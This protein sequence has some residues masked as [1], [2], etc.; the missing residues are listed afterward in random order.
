[1]AR[2]WVTALPRSILP[3]RPEIIS[4]QWTAL[5]LSPA[6]ATASSYGI[7]ASFSFNEI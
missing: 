6:N 2:I 4:C 3:F 1:M 7:F 5:S